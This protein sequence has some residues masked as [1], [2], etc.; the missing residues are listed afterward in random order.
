MEEKIKSDIPTFSQSWTPTQRFNVAAFSVQLVHDYVWST[1]DEKES[2][3]KE[4]VIGSPYTTETNIT[5]SDSFLILAC[6]GLWDVC[7]D[8]DAVNLVKDILDPQVASAKLIEHA[9]QNFSTDNLS[10]M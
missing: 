3:M 7:N 10:V 1:K 6:D 5:E 9:L 2:S 4:Y 8:Q